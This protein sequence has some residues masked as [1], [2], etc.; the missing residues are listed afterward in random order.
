MK[1]TLII[2]MFLTAI[3]GTNA[4]AKPKS[5]IGANV[6]EARCHCDGHCCGSS[7]CN[8]ETTG[9]CVDGVPYCDGVP[10]PWV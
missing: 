1:T 10:C 6:L 8:E 3:I 9:E 2:S 5:D 4:M 7:W